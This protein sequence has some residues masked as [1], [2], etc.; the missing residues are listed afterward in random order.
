VAADVLTFVVADFSA[1]DVATFGFGYVP[2]SSPPAVPV[3]DLFGV[4]QVA[5]LLEV[6]VRTCPELGAA[7][8]EVAT[9]E[10]DDFNPP[11]ATTKGVGYVPLRSPP[12]SPDG[13]PPA[14]SCHSA[15]ESSIAVS[16]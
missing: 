13:E 7:A 3:G 5:E 14:A 8:D 10:L 12:A 6:A 1:A 4:C 11:E 2:L 16:T 9:V 15:F